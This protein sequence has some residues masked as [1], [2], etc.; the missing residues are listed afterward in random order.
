MSLA[1]AEHLKYPNNGIIFS[2]LMKNAYDIIVV[3]VR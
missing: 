3:T 2:V 1:I